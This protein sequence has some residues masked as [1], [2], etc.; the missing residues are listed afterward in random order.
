MTACLVGYACL[1]LVTAPVN[2]TFRTGVKKLCPY[3]A[4]LA[5]EQKYPVRD[6][7]NSKLEPETLR[8]GA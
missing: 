7:L 6:R 2:P 8:P 1:L 5:V 4:P 3:S